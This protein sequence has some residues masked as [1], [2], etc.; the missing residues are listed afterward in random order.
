MLNMFKVNN[1]NT[2][3]TSLNKV[4]TRRKNVKATTFNYR[5]SNVILYRRSDTFD[6]RS[7]I[8]SRSFFIVYSEHILIVYTVS[9]DI[10]PLTHFRPMFH[11][12]THWKR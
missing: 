1:E 8:L 3:T 5:F 7:N 9:I 11:F 4:A 10:G 12:Y 6:V 2:K